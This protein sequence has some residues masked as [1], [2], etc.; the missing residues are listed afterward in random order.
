MM[1]TNKPLMFSTLIG[2]EKA[3][4]ILNRLLEKKSLPHVLLFH[5]PDGVGKGHFALEIAQKLMG[6]TKKEHPD[7]HLICQIG[8]A[9][10]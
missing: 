7:I 8:R 10:V 6:R 1:S 4:E 3:K 2:N 9:H 5:G